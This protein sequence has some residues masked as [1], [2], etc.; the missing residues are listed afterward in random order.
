MKNELVL[1]NSSVE[2]KIPKVASVD[3]I[4]S[5]NQ[6]LTTREVQQISIAYQS[7]A[8]EMAASFIWEKAMNKL[9]TYI[10]SFGNEFALEML[11]M[12]D[13][14]ILQKIPEKYV[15]DLSY[16]LGIISSPG[17]MKLTQC[18]EFI[19]YYLS[20]SDDEMDIDTINL[21]IRSC[22]EY[23]L[24]LN[25]EFQNLEFCSFR[26]SLKK[27]SLSKESQ[28]LVNICQA[29][30]FYKKTIVRTLLNL[31]DSTSGIEQDN[32]FN[33]L[34]LIIPLIWDS[35]ATEDKWMVGTS[36]TEAI[37]SNETRKIS[38][39]KSLLLKI[40]GFD[41]VPENVRSNT[42]IDAA[43]K[44]IAV[45]YSMNNF[46]NEPAAVDYL[47]SLGTVIPSHAVGACISA[48]LCVKLGNSYGISFDAQEKADV[49]LQPLS[50]DKKRYY[51]EKILPFDEDILNKLTNKNCVERWLNL[52][53]VISDI[54]GIKTNNININRILKYTKEGLVSE[55]IEEANKLKKKLYS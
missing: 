35:V 4:M 12:K 31:I 1:W 37:N 43:K 24:Q 22:V 20:H 5:Y 7:E 45:H 2:N 36:Y 17:K 8:F 30:Y 10:L 34:S 26:D 29:P 21:I 27:D 55:V 40:K 39:L 9:R 32:A 47:Y 38:V 50:I 42:F 46:Y 51:F 49:L 13:I 54:E 28:I 53:F 48:L 6:T 18:N 33:N 41:Y 52:D 23:V 16:E 11:G 15:I 3:K 14:A 25:V 19:S 44:I